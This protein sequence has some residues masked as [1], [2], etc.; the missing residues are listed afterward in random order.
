M[1]NIDC[2]YFLINRYLCEL[3]LT[4]WEED[5]KIKILLFIVNVSRYVF[6]SDFYVYRI[7]RKFFSEK[8]FFVL[9]Y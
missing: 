9:V 5:L 8:I 6:F 1:K 2:I 3:G 7:E 4:F